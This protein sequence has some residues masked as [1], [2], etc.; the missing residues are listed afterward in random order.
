MS[1]STLAAVISAVVGL[2]AAWAITVPLFR[3]KELRP[4]TP[5]SVAG[6]SHMVIRA[7]YRHAGCPRCH[8]VNSTF[9]WPPAIS[10]LRGCGVCHLP[11]PG[12]LVALQVGLPVALVL[13]ALRFA[14]V[15]GTGAYVAVLVAYG[16]FAVLAA[17]VAVVDARIW[18]IPWWMPWLGSAVGLV[19]LAIAALALDEPGRIL[20]AVVSA[21]AVFVLFYLLFV[22][23][24]GKLGFG[25]VRLVVPIGLFT[26]FYDPLL[27][28]WA[29]IIGS[30]LGVVVGL[31]STLRGRGGHFAF[32]PALVGGAL[33][34][35]WLAPRLL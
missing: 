13:N 31:L 29:L 22:L 10:W 5:R 27:V 33:L 17:A 23:A 3:Y 8:H 15:E 25:D 11:V 16:C 28:L 7:A 2:T 34:A 26:G 4:M 24:P 30:V 12:V 35:I 14:D 6:E 18:L 20:R 19:T 21:A 32:G 9:G 1:Q